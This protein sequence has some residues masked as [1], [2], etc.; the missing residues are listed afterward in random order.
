MSNDIQRAK[1]LQVIAPRAILDDASWTTVEIDTQDW[2]YLT[3]IFNLGA[4]DIG[5]T[6]LKMQSGDVAGTT[7]D[8]TGLIMGTSA[9][10]DGVTS[11]LPSA[12][13]DNNVIVF[14]ADLRVNNHRYWDLTA[15]VGD[16]S[17]GGFASAVA[18]LT[19]GA[20][21]P[22]TVSDSNAETLLRV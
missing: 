3:V 10:I 6:A 7:A 13:D 18:I 15:T 21:A 12:T 11:V 8:V 2:D 5:I 9:D 20:V 1:F 14:Q 22:V 16:G 19:K 17:T 4:T